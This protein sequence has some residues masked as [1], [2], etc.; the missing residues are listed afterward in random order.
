MNTHFRL[1]VKNSG[2]D[3]KFSREVLFQRHRLSHQ[4][5]NKFLG[6]QP[7]VLLMEE[8]INQLKQV[9]LFL[10]IT[11]ALQKADIWFVAYKGP[12]LSYRIYNDVTYRRFKDFDFLIKPEEIPKTIAVLGNLGFVPRSFQWP[13]SGNKEKRLLLFLNQ[14]TLDHPSKDI[15]VEIHWSLLKYPVIRQEIFDLIIQENIQET[16]FSGQ[17]FYQFSIEF[18]LLHLVIHGG[19]HTWS[20]L[21]WLIDIHEIINRFHVDKPKFEILVKLLH[22]QRLVG[23]CNAML[24]HYFPGTVLLPVDAPTPEWFINYSLHQIMRSTD[25]P[26]YLPK[27]LIT[28]RWFHI[29]AFSH[30]KYKI[31]KVSLLFVFYIQNKRRKI[32]HAASRKQNFRVAGTK[33]K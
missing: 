13:S 10:E 7:H 12:L 25:T 22:A 27:D 2:P 11:T 29:Q 3:I 15:S 8:K 9:A 21:K 14:Y 19:L 16:V 5:I 18:E 6:E 26:V 31:M 30:W 23:L 33:I 28:Y 17:K 32:F 4:Q 20:R 24:S 1:T